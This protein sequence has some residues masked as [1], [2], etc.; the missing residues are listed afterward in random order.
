MLVISLH[1]VT[2]SNEV[3]ED[4]NYVI[5]KKHLFII[6]RNFETNF[7]EF[8]KSRVNMILLVIIKIDRVYIV[9]TI[10]NLDFH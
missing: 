2:W 10:I 4:T 3:A 8:F 7:F 6:F 5:L 9:K 1:D